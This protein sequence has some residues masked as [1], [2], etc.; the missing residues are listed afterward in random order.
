MNGDND[1]NLK[2]CVMT[3]VSNS[4]SPLMSLPSNGALLNYKKANSQTFIKYI[5]SHSTN[6]PNDQFVKNDD[7]NILI[8]SLSKG[9]VKLHIT[10]K[11][12]ADNEDLRE[13]KKRIRVIRED[14]DDDM[15]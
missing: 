9:T 12:D 13:D 11:R 14:I 15:E 8:R 3:P 4:N 6:P 2:D 7:T 10:P 1:K 5:P